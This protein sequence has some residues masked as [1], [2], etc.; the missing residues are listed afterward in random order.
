MPE[1]SLACGRA[2]GG[3]PESLI[4]NTGVVDKLTKLALI[5][6]CFS[7]PM[8]GSPINWNLVLQVIVR[9]DDSMIR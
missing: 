5:S 3:F 1:S 2:S 8:G 6:T 4:R 9:V 7:L